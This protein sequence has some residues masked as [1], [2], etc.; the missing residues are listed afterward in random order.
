MPL[1]GPHIFPRP[2]SQDADVSGKHKTFTLR[3]T[4]SRSINPREGAE[5]RR[6][7][8]GMCAQQ[9]GRSGFLLTRRPHWPRTSWVS[10]FL[11]QAAQL[12][13]QCLR[14]PRNREVAHATLCC[15]AGHH[16]VVFIPTARSR[17]L[18]L[19]EGTQLAPRV[20][21]WM[22]PGMV[23]TDLT[24]AQAWLFSWT[25]SPRRQEAAHLPAARVLLICSLACNKM[26]EK[27]FRGYSEMTQ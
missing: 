9:G 12:Q 10:P 3:E 19:R 22:R 7:Q 23:C 25:P 17:R 11:L 27:V 14:F 2:Y 8:G 21:A 1:P 6:S 20:R 13:G 15:A 4:Q 18:P 16:G 5:G 26:M 24:E